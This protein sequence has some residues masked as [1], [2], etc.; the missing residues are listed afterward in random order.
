MTMEKNSLIIEKMNT[1]FKEASQ[2]WLKKIILEKIKSQGIVLSD[3]KIKALME[4]PKIDTPDDLDK[5]FNDGENKSDNPENKKIVKIIFGDEDLKNIEDMSNAFL[6]KIP[7]ITKMSIEEDSDNYFQKKYDEAAVISENENKKIKEFEDGLYK[8]WQKPLMLLEAYVVLTYETCDGLKSSTE[9]NVINFV[10]RRLG[11]KALQVS[12]EVLALM[13]SG[14]SRGAEARWRTLHEIAVTAHFIAGNNDDLAKRYID[15]DI[16][17]SYYSAVQYQS[18][19]ERLG[20]EPIT[21]DEFKVIKD[22]F[23]NITKIHGKE[24]K[25]KLGWASKS[26][27]KDK[28]NFV[29][30]EDSVKL[31]HWRPYYKNA[32]FNVHAGPKLIF[33]SLDNSSKQ[34]LAGPSDAGLYDPGLSLAF[35]LLQFSSAYLLHT[36]GSYENIIK[37]K[38]LNSFVIEIQK[39]FLKFVPSKNVKLIKK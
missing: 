11:A 5:I 25:N 32:S 12:K 35:S 14:F 17:E 21:E 31:D 18:K 7:S 3:E 29:D 28:P 30:I 37:F 16:V 22:K 39:E 9:G 38:M 23:E 33:N 8:R 13:K 2:N 6:T 34:I 27:K 15:Y 26:L 1:L 24:F 20:Y 10:L 19:C 36:N 4:Y